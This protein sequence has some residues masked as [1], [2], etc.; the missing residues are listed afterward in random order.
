MEIEMEKSK[1]EL[2]HR[3]SVLAKIRADKTPSRQEVQKKIAALLGIDDKLIVI[4]KISQ[5][6]GTKISKAYIKVYDNMKALREI[7][8]EYRLKRTGTHDE[9]IKE[10]KPKEDKPKEDKP[11][12]DKP[13]ED[14]PKE[15]KPKEDKPKEDK[16]K[17][18]KPK[19]DKE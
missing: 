16:P 11:K 8:L 2:L 17:E 5:D 10:D 7:E 15:E 1:N 18:E 3:T 19:E 14:K 12:E 6:Y 4:D 13:K 9:P